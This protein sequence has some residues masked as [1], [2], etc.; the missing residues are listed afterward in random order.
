VASS[1]L[2]YI[3]FP[4]ST[5]PFD[6]RDVRIALSQAIDR[7]SLVESVFSGGRI[8]AT[9]MLPPSAGDI[10]RENA[11]AEV[12]PAG[13]AIDAARARV[14]QS[15]VQLSGTKI[16]LY[17]NEDFSNRKI[18]EFVASQ[19]RTAFGLEAELVSLPW[20][21][22]LARANA[23]PTF[24][25]PFRMSWAPEYPSAD[26]YLFPLFHSD[27]IG[28]DNLT[29]FASATFDR[30]MRRSA[31]RAPTQEDVKIEYQRLETLACNS[32]PLAP[33]TFG[34]NEYFASPRLGSAT[35]NLGAG[36]LG[37]PSVRELYVRPS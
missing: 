11:C 1:S 18:L 27:S 26:R 9:G 17:F 28:S 14:N 30:L 24:D 25:G 20:E 37:Q 15:G 3:G 10:Y 23:N 8:P 33:L 29:R 12:V 35:E 6:N 36:T 32:M 2:E 16:K 5:P 22:Y 7:Q 31:R 4:I 34:S 19:W 21:D 13:G